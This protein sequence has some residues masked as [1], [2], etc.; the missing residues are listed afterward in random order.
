MKGFL[1]KIL[2]LEAECRIIKILISGYFLG[3]FL[4]MYKF[5]TNFEKKNSECFIISC[6]TTYIYIEYVKKFPYTLVFYG[7]VAMIGFCGNVLLYHKLLN[8]TSAN[9]S[10]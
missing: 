9:R 2:D 5:L 8:A 3:S 6:H 4:Q 1:K 10:D 7:V